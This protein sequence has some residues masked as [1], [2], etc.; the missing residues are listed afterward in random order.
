MLHHLALLVATVTAPHHLVYTYKVGAAMQASAAHGPAQA[1]F[2]KASAGANSALWAPTYDGNNVAGTIAIDVVQPLAPDGS[3]AFQVTVSGFNG[4]KP[5]LCAAYGESGDVVCNADQPLRPE[6]L[7]LLRVTGPNFYSPSRLDAK[8][9]WHI[10]SSSGRFKET[11]D[12]TVTKDD[13][14]D[15]TIAMSR[16]GTQ[17]QP[18]IDSTVEGTVVYD[19]TRQ[20]PTAIHAT[21]SLTLHGGASAG[22][23]ANATRVDL[24]LQR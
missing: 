2:D 10:A 3:A 15:L 14:S 17:Q 6:T 24:Q 5:F 20:I 13:G 4:G 11:A 7:L 16:H 22:D 9:H 1:A 19:D 12:F 8:K 21:L 18:P 23:S